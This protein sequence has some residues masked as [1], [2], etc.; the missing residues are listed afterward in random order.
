MK[1]HRADA[2]AFDVARRMKAAPVKIFVAAMLLPIMAAPAIATN[3]GTLPEGAVPL[4]AAETQ[5][6]YVGHTCEIRHSQRGRPLHMEGGRKGSRDL[7]G[8]KRGCLPGGGRL[9]CFWQ[10]VLL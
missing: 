7:G 8:K 2:V 3:D 10:P 5:A 4:T 6:L 1:T 9:D